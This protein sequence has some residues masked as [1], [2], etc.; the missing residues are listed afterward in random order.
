[1]GWMD[2]MKPADWI[3]L[4]QLGTSIVG[5]V[6]AGG[7][8]NRASEQAEFDRMRQ[9][10]AD[11]FARQLQYYQMQQQARS[12]LGAFYNQAN[13]DRATGRQAL[14][15]ASPLGAEQELAY[16]MARARG[17]SG[18][19]ENFQPAMPTSADIA[20]LIRPTTNILG[21]FTTPDFRQAI[22]PE[23]TARS[24]AERRKALAGVDPTFQFGSMGDYGLPNL[25]KEVA[26]YAQGVAAD[27]LSREN[28]LQDLLVQ[29]AKAATAFP[30]TV[31][32]A[33]G[34]QGVPPSQTAQTQKPKKNAWWKKVLNVAATAAPIVAAPFT[35]GT[36][37]A[38]IGA[39]AGA[40]KGA[41]SG[42]AKGALTGA[43][44]GAA[45]SAIG[46]GA[47]GAAAKRGVS[48]GIKESASAAIK[49]A[50]LNP[51]ALTQ[52]GGAAVGGRTEQLAQMASPFLPGA[53][54][55]R[56]GMVPGFENQLPPGF[57][58][59]LQPIVGPGA[60][61]FSTEF[62]SPAPSLPSRPT[63]QGLAPLS[64]NL[65][66]RGPS[67]MRVAT[68]PSQIRGLQIPA[69]QFGLPAGNAF[70]LSGAD[71]SGFDANTL[72]ALERSR[73]A[74][75]PFSSFEA[76][77]VGGLP[78]PLETTG[79]KA[80]FAIP[81]S[82][83]LGVGAAQLPTVV[84]GA[85]RVGQGVKDAWTYMNTSP[86]MRAAAQRAA[87]QGAPEAARDA[88]WAAQ[89]ASRAGTATP[90]AGRTANAGRDAARVAEAIRGAGASGSRGP[91]G[92]FRPPSKPRVT[93]GPTQ[94]YGP[95]G[96]PAPTMGPQG[97]AFVKQMLD[98]YQKHLASGN[99]AA[100]QATLE[101]AQPFLKALLGVR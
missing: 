93:E 65:M 63:T 87:Q 67:V 17:L 76:A 66:Q 15:N 4:G 94:V 52:L 30:Q 32:Q 95:K 81:M 12:G 23:A 11:E 39:G 92:G 75:I 8:A 25:E 80:A 90:G 13:M 36:S 47:A 96:P 5:G 14:L 55:F 68:A 41:L 2:Q 98:T 48:E 101:K 20:G 7:A 50:I 82:V 85:G 40:L 100:A 91:S 38:L 26:T 45:T 89:A 19:A 79:Q 35:G 9:E 51:R 54:A 74:P 69:S 61:G 43:A 58:G 59:P 49:R 1:M 64:P 37:L 53:T 42:G 34:M 6:A 27:R 31:A 33:Q 22:S 18:V 46:G 21:A 62:T 57:Q 44:M 88:S 29:Q 10:R 99:L 86:A 16:Q 56:P 28:Q 60:E 84:A 78:P 3:N 77:K 24:I 73:P 97:E 83:G 71:F 72:A 70:D